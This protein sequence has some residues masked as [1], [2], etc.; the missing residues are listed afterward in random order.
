M[1][2][3]GKWNLLLEGKCLLIIPKVLQEV[4]DTRVIILQKHKINQRNYNFI[5]RFL[6][7]YYHHFCCGQDRCLDCLAIMPVLLISISCVNSISGCVCTCH[8]CVDFEDW[9]HAN[10]F[11]QFCIWRIGFQCSW[12]KETRNIRK[13][14]PI[15]T[16]SS[17]KK[18]YERNYFITRHL[19]IQSM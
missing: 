15:H 12:W 8:H 14:V 4:N 19:Q 9:C 1:R 2:V 16:T 11:I 5:F 17:W 6:K 10:I 18:F 7:M 3:I 13:P